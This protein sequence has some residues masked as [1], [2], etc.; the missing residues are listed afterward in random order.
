[1]D[2]IE[3][4]IFKNEITISW[5]RF[6]LNKNVLKHELIA[7]DL[8]LRP[9]GFSRKNNS[10]TENDRT[11]LTIWNVSKTTLY[12]ILYDLTSIISDGMY[13]VI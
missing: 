3:I 12:D 9:Y 2:K 8:V 13:E 6:P 11:L 4:L 1:M 7:M 10:Y 5:P